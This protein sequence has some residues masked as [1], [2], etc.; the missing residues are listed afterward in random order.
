MQ[1]S[2]WYAIYD[3]YLAA[4]GA[5]HLNM[6][7]VDG[8]FGCPG[9]LSDADR[10]EKARAV[11][12]GMLK[13]LGGMAH[14]RCILGCDCRSLLNHANA[15]TAD[16]CSVARRV[17]TEGAVLL[18]NAPLSSAPSAPPTH[19]LPIADGA[20]IAIVGSACDAHHSYAA[21]ALAHCMLIAC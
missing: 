18:K 8:A 1:V 10:D 7:G 12:R 21:H 3:A 5:V 6:P 20:T 17:A 15:T 19:A 9:L 13:N 16:H 14:P 11:V 4:K 2:D